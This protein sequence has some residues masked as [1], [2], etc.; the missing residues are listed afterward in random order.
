MSHV[1]TKTAKA[2]ATR[3][4]G[5]PGSR[6]RPASGRD[7]AEPGRGRQLGRHPRRSRPLRLRPDRAPARP[8]RGG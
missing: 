5:E 1:S 4:T 7:M 8:G 3:T 2:T 6:A